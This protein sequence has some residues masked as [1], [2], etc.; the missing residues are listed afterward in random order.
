MTNAIVGV[1][2][3]SPGVD[4]VADELSQA[5]AASRCRRLAEHGCRASSSPDDGKDFLS[6]PAALVETIEPRQ[7]PRRG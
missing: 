7:K 6:S 2:P 5:C 1:N 4:A 3:T